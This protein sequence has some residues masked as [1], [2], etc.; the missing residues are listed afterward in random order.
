VRLT[1]RALRTRFTL[2][3][4]KRRSSAPYASLQGCSATGNPNPWPS[5]RQ[6]GAVQFRSCYQPSFAGEATMLAT[7]LIR[8]S[9]L[10]AMLG[11]IL[12][13]VA[14][15]IHPNGEDLAAVSMSNWVPAHLLGFVSVTLIH[16]SLVGLYAH[17]VER[18]GWLGL[19]GF[20]LAF[21]GSAFAM[22]IQYVTSTV[23]PLIAAQAP[24]LFDQ[25]MTPPGFAPPLFVLGFILGHF[26]FG[27]ATIRAGMLPRW[28]GFLV[29]IGILLFF[30]GEV[31]FLGQGL[32]TPAFQQI[33]AL[34]RKL[35]GIV[36]LGDLAFGLGLA[37][38]GYS[39]WVEK[40][41]IASTG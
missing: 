3:V 29:V 30:L 13:P 27:L 35:H 37:S 12:F 4:R 7:N 31:S 2:R 26:L 21:V 9:G 10:I 20:V 14:A 5:L 19:I 28:S 23:I 33:F 15:V 1:K 38:M 24:A 41:Q 22:V 25:A 11:G 17:Q 18:A 39:L 36:L 40:R 34:I 16:L 8:W 6:I 32:P